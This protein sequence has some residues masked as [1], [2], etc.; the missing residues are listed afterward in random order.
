M[1]AQVVSSRDASRLL[2][3]PRQKIVFDCC[4]DECRSNEYN[5]ALG[6]N[7]AGFAMDCQRNRS[8][9]PFWVTDDVRSKR[10]RTNTMKT[11]ILVACLMS[12][13]IAAGAQEVVHALTGTVVSADATAK[14]ITVYTD[15]HS[16]GLFK[17]MTEPKTPIAF[18]KTIRAKAT[19][20]NEFRQKGTYGIV[21]Y[22]SGADTR[23]AVALRNLGQ[24]PFSLTTGTVVKSEDKGRSVV[25]TDESGA[26]KTF[27]ITDDT[28]AETGYGAVVGL[29]CQLHKGDKVRVTAKTVNG[30]DVALFIN[31]M[32]GN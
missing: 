24:G 2:S 25:V 5:L 10:M 11:C 32:V 4:S 12:A 26:S 13:L 23:T 9:S 22:F 31:A 21:F 16:A 8:D 30:T 18:D 15:N 3:Q 17:D 29:K 28:I 6:Q 14:T 20:A 7:R 19:A 1:T 27:N